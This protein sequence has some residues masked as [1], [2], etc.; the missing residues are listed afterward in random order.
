MKFFVQC[1]HPDGSVT[2]GMYTG[3]QVIEMMGYRYITDCEYK[4]Y[5]VSQFG[6]VEML[7]CVQPVSPT[8]NFY[9]FRNK[10]GDSLISGYFPEK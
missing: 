5:D 9:D 2:C 3:P 6:E 10:Q 7:T 8:S 4:V 1:E